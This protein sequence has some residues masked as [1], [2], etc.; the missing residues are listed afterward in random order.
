MTETELKLIRALDMME[1]L[2]DG[3]LLTS[4]CE[5]VP[6]VE[7]AAERPTDAVPSLAESSCL[8]RVSERNWRSLRRW[9]LAQ[10]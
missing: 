4:E 5:A 9:R 2:C 6:C 10:R 7:R 3:S 1:A 8:H